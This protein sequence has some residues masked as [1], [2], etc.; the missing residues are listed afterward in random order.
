MERGSDW[1]MIEECVHLSDCEQTGVK[2]LGILSSIVDSVLAK[3]VR[4]DLQSCPVVSTLRSDGAGPLLRM[5][6]D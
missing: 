3:E 5:W 1:P 6:L 4:H 2:H